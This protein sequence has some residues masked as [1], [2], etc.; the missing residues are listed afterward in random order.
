MFQKIPG[1]N[2]GLSL[3]QHENTFPASNQ[4]VTSDIS[5][6]SISKVTFIMTA[7]PQSLAVYL[8]LLPSVLLMKRDGISAK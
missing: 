6:L 5:L 1:Q 2:V 7:A 3:N 4:K 8:M